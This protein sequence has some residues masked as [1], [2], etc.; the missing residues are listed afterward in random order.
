MFLSPF[1]L[2]RARHAYYICSNQAVVLLWNFQ[3]ADVPSVVSSFK[4]ITTHR[5]RLQDYIVRSISQVVYAALWFIL[6]S[7]LQSILQI[8]VS[9]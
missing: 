5:V 4:I 6:V 9:L 8:A 3:E 7:Q 1:L 2:L